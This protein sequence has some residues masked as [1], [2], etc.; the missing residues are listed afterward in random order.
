[1]GPLSGPPGPWRALRAIDRPRRRLT[2]IHRGCATDD[3]HQIDQAPGATKGRADHLSESR[4]VRRLR[5]RVALRAGLQHGVTSSAQLMRATLRQIV[6]P[7]ALDGRQYW[8]LV[9]IVDVHV[10]YLVLRAATAG[11][12]SSFRASAAR[13]LDKRCRSAS[14]VIPHTAAAS[15]GVSP[16]CAMSST[17]SR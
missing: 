3:L 1:M 6:S 16:S 11:V 7:Q 8:I 10:P 13:A 17:T 9:T 5:G 15:M 14:G 4:A 2:A 12:S